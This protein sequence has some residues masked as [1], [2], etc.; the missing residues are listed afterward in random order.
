MRQPCSLPGPRRRGPG[1]RCTSPRGQPSH[2][3]PCRAARP[4]EAQPGA[5]AAA[6]IERRHRL[7]GRGTPSHTYTEPASPSETP[8]SPLLSSSFY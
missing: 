6:Q 7:P 1:E 4:M 3:P 2:A 5:S 8:R